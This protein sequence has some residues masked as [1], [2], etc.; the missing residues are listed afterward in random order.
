MVFSHVFTKDVIKAIAKQTGQTQKTTEKVLRTAMPE[1]AAKMEA[2]AKTQ[3]GQANILGTLQRSTE[4]VKGADGVERSFLNPSSLLSGLLGNSLSGILTNSSQASGASQDVT[5]QILAAAAPYMLSSLFS[6]GSNASANTAQQAA[7]TANTAAQTA[8]N[9][10]NSAGS[11]LGGALGSALLGSLLGGGNSQNSSN[12]TAGNLA[13]ALLGG[14][15]NQ[16]SSGG[17][18]GG[19]LG[20]ALLGSLLG[21]GQSSGSSN[22]GS[23][24]GGGLLSSLAGSL[25]SGNDE[26]E[27]EPEQQSSGGGGGLLNFFTSLVSTDT[28]G[29]R[30]V[31]E[32]EENKE[33]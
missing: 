33:E 29:D 8:N 25:F 30:S 24:L 18:L 22:S 14:S 12:N 32:E 15:N 27:P 6:G 23:G 16:Q 26:P 3:E 21:G 19:A 9:A 4:V 17:G 5:S 20:S 10:N 1:M 28:S 11:G 7:S 2:D 13:S 31:P